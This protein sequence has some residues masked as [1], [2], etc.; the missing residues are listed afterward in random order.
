MIYTRYVW[1]MFNDNIEYNSSCFYAS[2]DMIHVFWCYRVKTHHVFVS[3]TKSGTCS[4]T[5]SNTVS[6]TTSCTKTEGDLVVMVLAASDG[7]I[8]NVGFVYDFPLQLMSSR[9]L[10]FGCS[11]ERLLA[12][13]VLAVR[14][15]FIVIYRI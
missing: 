7:W 11:T 12:H 4:G 2:K 3:G 15:S 10:N 14:A 1:F 6:S 5:R 9:Q 8:R 13:F